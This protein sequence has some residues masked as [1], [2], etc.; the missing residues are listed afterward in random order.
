MKTTQFLREQDAYA[1]GISW[2]RDFGVGQKVTVRVSGLERNDFERM[3]YIA[4]I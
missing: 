1:P 4:L 3:D 2:I